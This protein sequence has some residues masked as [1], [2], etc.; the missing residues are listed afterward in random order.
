V[1]VLLAAGALIWGY[2]E[3]TAPGPLAEA[4]A[5]VIAKGLGVEGIGRRLA[6]GGVIRDPRVFAIG[7]H[8]FRN[9]HALRAGEYE[10]PAHA[11]AEQAMEVLIYA[12]P[13]VRRL[14]IAEGLTTAEALAE[15]E[16]NEALEGPV[17]RTP[18]EGSLLPETYNFSWGES[19]ESLVRRAEKA[20]SE[21]LEGLWQA[22]APDLALTT[23][24]QALVLASIVEKETA[25]PEERPRV[26]AVFLNRLRHRMRLQSDPTVV[27]ALTHGKG[28]LGH[29]LAHAD[30]DAQSRYNTYLVDGLPPTP[31]DNPGKASITAVL[32]P[33]ASDD[34]YFVADGSGGHLFARTLAEHNRNVAKLRQLQSGSGAEKAE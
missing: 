26:A 3:F 13:V 20:M 1:L 24:E 27:Y 28:P 9:R 12:K 16:R 11:S 15:I 19:R 10:F 6:E 2:L 22:R 8:L 31:I 5:L 18:A 29:A 32:H 21:T 17:E 14:T 30:L 34:L 25:R 33:A 23:P 4:S 7:V